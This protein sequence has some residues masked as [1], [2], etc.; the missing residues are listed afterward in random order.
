VDAVAHLGPEYVVDEAVLGDA[1]QAGERGGR[2]DG[3]EVMAVTR[4]LGSS[5][6]NPR[7]DP[8]LQLLWRSRHMAKRSELIAI[9][10]LAEA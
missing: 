5:A 6:G 2:D 9:A 7:L 8:L 4:D 3:V 1:G 10:I